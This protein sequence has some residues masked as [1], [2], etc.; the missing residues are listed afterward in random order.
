MKMKLPI[1]LFTLILPYLG[2]KELG[3]IDLAFTNKLLRP[4]F[5]HALQKQTTLILEGNLFILDKHNFIKWLKK[6]QIHYQKGV[7]HNPTT[8]LFN[9]VICVQQHSL[10]SIE[11]PYGRVTKES[12]GV[13]SLLCPNIK[14]FTYNNKVL[15]DE[16]EIDCF[17]DIHSEFIDKLEYFHVNRCSNYAIL[18]LTIYGKNLSYIKI[19]NVRTL[20]AAIIQDFVQVRHRTCKIEIDLVW[21]VIVNL[22]LILQKEPNEIFDIEFDYEDINFANHHKINRMFLHHKTVNTLTLLNVFDIHHCNTIFAAIDDIQTLVIN[23]VNLTNM[24]SLLD[25]IV[26]K[27]VQAVKIIYVPTVVEICINNLILF[28]QDIARS[29]DQYKYIDIVID[30]RLNIV[31]DDIVFDKFIVLINLLEQILKNENVSLLRINH[32]LINNNTNWKNELYYHFL[33]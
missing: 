31:N 8:F 14:S 2:I 1:D 9:S 10:Q 26:E 29:D 17:Y 20:N 6:R 24:Q 27:N 4:F 32:K 18:L 11:I 3:N 12:M 7:F 15:E 21:N 30:F 22:I 13:M 28:F 33:F 19:D 25:V 16:I 23:G 5:L